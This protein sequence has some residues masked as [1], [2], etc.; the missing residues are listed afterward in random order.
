MTRQREPAGTATEC[1][2]CKALIVWTKTEKGKLMPCDVGPS[3]DGKFHLFRRGGPGG[4][5][6]AISVSSHHASVAVALER[7]QKR[8]NS[9]FSTCPY[10]DSHRKR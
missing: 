10:A 8:H 7:N 5:I 6:E 3:E 4:Y 9:H 2:S 1:R